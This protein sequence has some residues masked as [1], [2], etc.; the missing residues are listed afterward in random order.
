MFYYKVH[1]VHP[2][3][4]IIKTLQLF[5]YKNKNNNK[6]KKKIQQQQKI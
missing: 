5:Y 1:H 6:K 4:E 3:K 2:E